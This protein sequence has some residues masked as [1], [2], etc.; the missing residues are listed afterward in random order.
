MFAIRKKVNTAV[1]HY[2]KYRFASEGYEDVDIAVKVET[3][4]TQATKL[5]VRDLIATANPLEEATLTTSGS[6]FSG[7]SSGEVG[8][9][10]TGT[11]QIGSRGE[12]TGCC[13]EMTFVPTVDTTLTFVGTKLEVLT[14]AQWEEFNTDVDQPSTPTLMVAELGTQKV[15]TL[16]GIEGTENV[17]RL[18]AHNSDGKVE[19]ALGRWQSTAGTDIFAVLGTDQL[20]L[21]DTARTAGV[22]E[23]VGFDAQGSKILKAN[24]TVAA[25]DD[26]TV[27]TAAYFTRGEYTWVAFSIN[28]NPDPDNTN[29]MLDKE[30]NAYLSFDASMLV[31]DHHTGT[32]HFSGRDGRGF[33]VG[34]NDFEC[35]VG[36]KVMARVL[37][38]IYT[39][40][41]LAEGS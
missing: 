41:C 1:Y 36:H 16:F 22:T 18:E 6:N 26:T 3:K 28:P 29:Y 8:G 33:W 15:G 24:L 13:G 34:I 30:K 23:L 21:T 14:A 11:L 32:I 39:G 10:Y 40:N 4:G 5:W 31:H 27:L 35:L 9:T 17:Q 7:V 37:G 19:G 25:R 20:F 2:A 38:K 12:V